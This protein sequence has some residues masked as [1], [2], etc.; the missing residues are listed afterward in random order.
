M[1]SQLMALDR[2]KCLRTTTLVLQLL[3]LRLQI[4][5]KS[6]SSVFLPPGQ[7]L[8]RSLAAHSLLQSDNRI[9]VKTHYHPPRL[10]L[11]QLGCQTLSSKTSAIGYKQ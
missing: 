8:A 10:R 7:S 2:S 6:T 11:L 9:I 3:Q 4:L 1:Q 5:L